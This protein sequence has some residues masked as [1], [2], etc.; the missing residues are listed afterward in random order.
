MSRKMRIRAISFIV[1]GIIVIVGMWACELH[2]KNYYK[3][4]LENEYTYALYELNA[5]L[6]NISIILEKSRYINDAALLSETASRLYSEAELAK[7]ALSRLPIDVGVYGT[8][9][10]FLSQV[11]NYSLS[12]ARSTIKGMEISKE[13]AENLA[14]L[15]K[16]AATIAQTVG[17]TQLSVNNHEYWAS[18]LEDKL[19]SEEINGDTLDSSL[20][21]L[22]ENLTDF[23]TLIYDGPFSE[24]LLHREPLLLKEKEI[25]TRTEAEQRVRSVVPQTGHLSY[26]ELTESEI[27]VHLFENEYVTVAVS[28][29]GGYIVYLRANRTT[30]E[31]R[32][33]YSQALSKAKLFLNQLELASMKASY[34]FTDNGICVINFAAV[35]NDVVCYPDLVKVGVALDNGEIVFYESGGYIYNHTKR[36]FAPI[37]YTEEQA[38][39]VINPA[40]AP[41][42]NG[43]AVIPTDGA[44]EKLCYEFSCTTEEGKEILVYINAE[45]LAEEQILILLKND[46]GTLVK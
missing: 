13:Q 12:I 35:Q 24:H 34:Y 23:P 14:L 42:S 30:G 36:E 39:Q 3:Q 2:N 20:S 1:A 31:A 18:E 10:R 21:S 41:Q 28:Q 46:G 38:R 22:E 5:G 40:L 37:Q 26:R 15:S 44:S 33:S 16:T 43:L 45:T 7:T 27:A 6:N 29:K 32:L 8:V 19:S 9:S 4:Q 17:D 25:V 11:G